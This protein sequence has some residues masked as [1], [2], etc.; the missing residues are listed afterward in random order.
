M[1]PTSAAAAAAANR[2][3]SVGRIRKITLCVI[4]SFCYVCRY[5]HAD[6]AT[7]ISWP[8]HIRVVGLVVACVRLSRDS[9]VRLQ[10]VMHDAWCSTSWRMRTCHPARERAMNWVAEGRAGSDAEWRRRIFSPRSSIVRWRPRCWD[11]CAAGDQ[12][13]SI[14]RSL[15]VF[16][17]QGAASSRLLGCYT[18]YWQAEN[19]RCGRGRDSQRGIQPKMYHVIHWE[20]TNWFPIGLLY[21]FAHCQ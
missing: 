20:T 11:G 16:W 1:D 18:V 5:R 12:R 13:P 10:E 8:S 7:M 6:A 15:A 19:Q 14:S 2:D 21:R 17:P 3:D 4:Q 9:F